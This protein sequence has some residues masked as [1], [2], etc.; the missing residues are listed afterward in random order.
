MSTKKGYI[1]DVIILLQG[2]PVQRFLQ[3]KW[4]Q[5]LI[6]L[7]MDYKSTDRGM[8]SEPMHELKANH[9]SS[10]SLKTLERTTPAR[11]RHTKALSLAM[12][13]YIIPSI[14]G[15]ATFNQYWSVRQTKRTGG[16]V[17]TGNHFAAWKALGMTMGTFNYMIVA[18]EG[19]YSTGS[20]D[21]TVGVG[22]SSGSSG[23]T[24]TTAAGTTTTTSTSSAV[25]SRFQ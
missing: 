21:I 14:Q 12:E 3:P 16:T 5:L 15:T 7:W 20:S 8:F 23:T 11:A 18:T 4:Q 6:H 13:A 9:H 1:S 17:N 22:S 2:C 10:T 25:S 24:T 19:Y